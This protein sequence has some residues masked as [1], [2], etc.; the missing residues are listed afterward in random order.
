M[1]GQG[2]CKRLQPLLRCCFSLKPSCAGMWVCVC[3]YSVRWCHP[4]S[5]KM[6]TCSRDP[7]RKANNL[8]F[9]VLGFHHVPVLN[10]SVP[11]CQ[12]AWCH[13]SPVLSL[14]SGWHSKQL[15]LKYPAAHESTPFLWWRALQCYSWHC[16]APEKQSLTFTSARAM[17]KYSKSLQPD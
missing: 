1:L 17:L 15:I 13:S 9:C 16:S 14:V 6:G 7:Y 2:L 10:L 8:L 3:V 5:L 11:G 12:H 4:L